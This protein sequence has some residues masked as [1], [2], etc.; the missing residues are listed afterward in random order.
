MKTKQRSIFMTGLV[1]CL[2]AA[3][4]ISLAWTGTPATQETALPDAP[5]IEIKQSSLEQI[6]ERNRQG[7]NFFQKVYTR[8][9]INGVTKKSEFSRLRKN[10]VR[11]ETTDSSAQASNDSLLKKYN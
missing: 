9:K 7:R 5:G 2:I 8:E 10:P 6:S 4:A 1:C 11:Y 3:G